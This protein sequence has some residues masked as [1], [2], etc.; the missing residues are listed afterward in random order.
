MM[1]DRYLDLLKKVLTGNIYQEE[2]AFSVV[3]PKSGWSPAVTAKR[4]IIKN[5]CISWHQ[6][7]K[8]M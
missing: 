4:M 8:I 1:D 6:T 2:S 3:E 7:H 5:C